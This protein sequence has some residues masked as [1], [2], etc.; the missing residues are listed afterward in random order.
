MKKDFFLILCLYLN[1][2]QS[3]HPKSLFT[4]AFTSVWAGYKKKG[5]GNRLTDIP[6][7]FIVVGWILQFYDA[8]SLVALGTLL[9]REFNFLIFVQRLAEIITLNFRVMDKNVI[10]VFALDKAVAFAVVKPFNFT[11][12]HNQ[13]PPC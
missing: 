11:F 9:D 10:T 7:P 2:H 4:L 8:G 5:P 3:P 6:G 1:L 12:W 13:V